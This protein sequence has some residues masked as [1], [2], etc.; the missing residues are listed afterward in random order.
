M[1]SKD[2]KAEQII[3][4]GGGA[5]GMMAAI[6]A[7]G[8]GRRVLLFEQNEKL[9]KKLYITGKGR[10]NL[11]NDSDVSQHLSAVVSNPRFLYSA[12]TQFDAQA[13]K[14]F[15]QQLGLPLKTERGNRVFPVS[16]HSSDV[17]KALEYECK[18]LGVEIRL[19]TKVKELL[20]KTEDT[21]Q[22]SEEQKDKAVN[23]VAGVLLA[24]GKKE[25]GQ[26]VIMAT[27]GVSYPSTGA[28]GSGLSMARRAGHHVTDLYPALVPLCTKEK[29]TAQLAGLSL[30]NISIS[31]KNGNKKLYEEFGEMLFTHRGVSGPVILS[32]SSYISH[33]LTEAASLRLEIDLK[34]ALDEQKLDQRLIR[35]LEQA[36]IKHI[37]NVCATLLPHSLIPVVLDQAGIPK[38]RRSCDIGK[39]E[40]MAL[41]HTLKSLTM[42]I[43]GTEGFD[44]AIIT[45]GGIDTREIHP[46][47]MESRRI[48]GLYFAGECIDV[49]ALTGG[50]NLQIAWATGYK[51]GLSAG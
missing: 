2:E 19:N 10:C 7:A 24:D 44:A 50:F 18:R 34:P 38:D 11:T 9:G 22:D 39:K 8:K 48:R 15:F 32:A 13:T 43:T 29:W 46:G 3:I 14:D 41:L 4:I 6:A 27:G 20:L 51:A 37:R 1:M 47:T 25:M 30:R 26:A 36:G 45:R 42:T 5:A 21:Q 40:R 23:A 12:Q 33:Y 28:D 16:D 49:D 17:I 31:I 35:E